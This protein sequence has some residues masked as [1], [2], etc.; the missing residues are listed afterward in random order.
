MCSMNL[1]IQKASLLKRFSAFL[2]DFILMTIAVTGFAALIGLITGLDGHID[3]LSDKQEHYVSLITVSESVDFDINFDISKENYDK[4]S[5]ESRASID[6]AYKAFQQDEEVVY[7]Y[8][9]IFNL[10]LLI[11]TFSMFLAFL[12]LEFAVPLLLKNGQTVGKKVFGIGVM[13]QNGIRVNNIAV[14][15]RAV[16]GKFTIECMIPVFILLTFLFG[17][18]GIVG[19]VVLV[20]ILILEVFVFFKDRLF[21]LIHDV[22]AHTVTVDLASQMIFATEEEALAY[23]MSLHEIAVKDTRS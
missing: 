15:I 14:F 7:A 22:M 8:N 16:L 6:A 1:E 20:L 17:G 11:A 2:L 18:S 13:H 4:L 10:T 3:K 23:R 21:M 19:L 9:M 12:L 5:E